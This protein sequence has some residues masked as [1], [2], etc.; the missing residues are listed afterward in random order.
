M[1]H[2]DSLASR[3]VETPEILASFSHAETKAVLAVLLTA[4]GAALAKWVSDGERDQ[5]VN[6]KAS[7]DSLLDTKEVAKRLGCSVATVMRR[8]KSGQYPFMLKDGGRLVGSED[9]LAR[10]IKARTAR[11]S[12]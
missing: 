2:S 3:V 8:W 1:N 6:Q 10:W 9:G 4:T 7:G 11:R 5:V 12:A